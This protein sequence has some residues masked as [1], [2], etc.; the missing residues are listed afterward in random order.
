RPQLV[1]LLDGPLCVC[2]LRSAVPCDVDPRV[3]NMR[4]DM[5]VRRGALPLLGGIEH[6]AALADVTTVVE[7]DGQN[8]DVVMN[9]GPDAARVIEEVSIAVE[10][11]AQPAAIP[12]RQACADGAREAG[13]ETGG[14]A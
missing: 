10:G 2:S 7:H 3:P 13:A 14:S 12:R 1:C 11:D 9:G 5:A 8:R 6:V 4:R